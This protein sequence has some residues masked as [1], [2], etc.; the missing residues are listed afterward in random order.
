ME[1]RVTHQSLRERAATMSGAMR[2][3]VSVAATVWRE[4]CRRAWPMAAGM[5]RRRPMAV[6]AA[7]MMAL[8]SAARRRRPFPAS[9]RYQ[10]KVKPPHFRADGLRLKLNAMRVRTGRRRKAA[11]MAP[12][13]CSH[14][15]RE[16]G[17]PVV[18][19]F[20]RRRSAEVSGR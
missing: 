11:E 18:R 20:M 19:S 8:F 2:G 14:H 16:R 6:A 12:W 1:K 7:A 10:W 3:R 15:G 13:R 4:R 9:C 5:P 17:S